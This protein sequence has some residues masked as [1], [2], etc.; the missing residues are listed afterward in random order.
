MSSVVVEESIARVNAQK[1]QARETKQK[2]LA[3]FLDRILFRVY[4]WYPKCKTSA[5]KMR[6]RETQKRRTLLIE[7]A[8]AAACGFFF[9]FLFVRVTNAREHIIV[10]GGGG[11]GV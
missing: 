2:T 10:P 1:D 4:Y 5:P 7:R 11:G 6:E 3:Y 8:T 9:L